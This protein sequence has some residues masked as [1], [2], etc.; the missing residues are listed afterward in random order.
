MN[1][2]RKSRGPGKRERQEILEALGPREGW[3]LIES[4]G[5]KRTAKRV[6][7][8]GRLQNQNMW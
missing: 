1:T 5:G 6:E 3:A 4:M 8:H 7:E 2:T